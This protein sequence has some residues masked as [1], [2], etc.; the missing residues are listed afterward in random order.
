MIK[1]HFIFD[2]DG[3]LIDSEPAHQQIF[4]KVFEELNLDFSAAYHHTLVGMAAVPMWEKIRSDFQIQTDARELM[5]FH[6]E[7]MYVEIKE[8][9]IQLV[10]GVYELLE[11]LHEMQIKMSLASSSAEKLIHYFVDKFGIRSK[12]DFLVSGESLTRSKPFPDIFLKVAELYDLKPD[13]FVVIEDSNNGVR[14]VKAADM[15]CIGYTNPNSGQQDLSL[16]DETISNFS[17]LNHQ[18]IKDLIH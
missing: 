15:L 14:A 5:N 18:K 11:R 7:F 13:R 6:K 10:P 1:D 8:L 16:A 4:K 12:F 17:Q 9:D 3:V 2:M